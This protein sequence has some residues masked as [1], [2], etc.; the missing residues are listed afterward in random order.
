MSAGPWVAGNAVELLEN[1]EEYFP[2]VF[3]AIR[4]AKQE[5]LI[6]TFILFEDEV[7]MQL[8]AAMMAAAARGV[9]I[10]LTVDGWGSCDLGETFIGPLTDAGVRVHRVDHQP[11]ILGFRTNMFRRMHRKMVVIDQ[12]LGFIGGINYSVDHLVCRGPN[13]KQDYAVQ[14][15]GPIVAHMHRFMRAALGQPPRPLRRL[16]NWARHRRAEPL[17][18]G[19]EAGNARAMLVTR[20]NNRHRDDIE[21]H[22]RAAIQ[23][24][25]HRLILANA[26]FLPGFRLLRQL[27]KAARRGVE[28]DLILQGKPDMPMA[29]W[30]S[31]AVYAYLI[32]AGVR[33]HEYRDRPLHG[34][35]A[36]MDEQWATVGSSNLDPFSL[37]LNLEANLMILDSD[38]N[39]VLSE[40]LLGLIHHSCCRVADSRARLTLLRG[41]ASALLLQLLRWFPR[42][43]ESLP[44]HSPS[45]EQAAPL[46]TMDPTSAPAI[47]TGQETQTAGVR[48]LSDAGL[49]P[50][51]PVRCSGNE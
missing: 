16:W 23:T 32:R 33:V 25:R 22:Y 18:V 47:R 20:D 50:I 48:G 45:V 38:F 26:Y 2:R 4:A 21:R 8:H 46:S 31:T 11:R 29:V 13:C 12:S 15:R 24:A 14:V 35:V 28:V 7:G 36:I 34:K 42:V 30:G 3:E 5:V 44:S 6:E 19:A 10:D 17:A 43:L 9:E 51:P 1:G 41:L 40:R 49:T 37:S 27:A 39:R